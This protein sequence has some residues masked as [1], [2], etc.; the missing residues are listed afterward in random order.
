[1]GTGTEIQAAG[2]I[3]MET[4]P[5]KITQICMKSEEIRQELGKAIARIGDCDNELN[6]DEMIQAT[7][8][9]LIN[10]AG[11][12]I[13]HLGLV[14]ENCEDDQP[15]AQVILELMIKSLTAHVNCA[16][17]RTLLVT[18]GGYS[19]DDLMS[20]LILLANTVFSWSYVPTGILLINLIICHPNC[21]FTGFDISFTSVRLK[22]ISSNSS[23]ICPLPKGF[24][25]PF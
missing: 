16:Q 2:V 3:L 10:L 1:M 12:L 23:T 24:S 21:V 5:D 6:E 7:T 19:L 4:R 25:K 22:A 13:G 9:A 18:D 11:G 15:P 20:L 14:Y 17:E 8:E